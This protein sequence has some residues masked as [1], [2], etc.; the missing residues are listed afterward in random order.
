VSDRAYIPLKKRLASA[1]LT[2]RVEENGKLVPFIDYETAKKLTADQIISLF[3]FDHWPIAKWMEGA[4]EP[5]NLVPRP[6]MEHRVKTAKYDTPNSAKAGRVTEANEEFR[7]KMLAKV[8]IGESDGESPSKSPKPKRR[9]KPEG[10][11]FNW[12]TGRYERETAE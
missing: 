5:W 9:W 7:R 12:Q 1:L 8:G 6:I 10:M 4:D 3:Q 11:K 2:I